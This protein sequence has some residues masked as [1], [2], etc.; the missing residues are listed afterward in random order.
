MCFSPYYDSTSSSIAYP[1][2]HSTSYASS[3]SSAN[4]TSKSP[5]VS[6]VSWR[7]CIYRC[8]HLQVLC[9]FFYI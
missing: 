6:T 9:S 3:N 7:K 8:V 5:L 1:S 2:I 4:T